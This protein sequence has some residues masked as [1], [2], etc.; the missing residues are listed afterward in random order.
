MFEHGGHHLREEQGSDL[1][2]KMVMHESFTDYVE[3]MELA[4]LGK[5]AVIKNNPVVSKP[6]P[7]RIQP[8]R[9]HSGSDD[10]DDAVV[11]DVQPFIPVCS[12]RSVVVLPSVVLTVMWLYSHR[13]TTS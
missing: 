8:P 5:R 3:N 1:T 11:F 12:L 9:S 4:H 10:A 2:L 7:L 13:A 6:R